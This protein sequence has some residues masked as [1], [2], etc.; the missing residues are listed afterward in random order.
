MT[1]MNLTACGRPATSYSRQSSLRPFPVMIMISA[2]WFTWSIFKQLFL[3]SISNQNQQ[4]PFYFIFA[5][6]DFSLSI[7]FLYF[8]LKVH[9]KTRNR[10]RRT[11]N[12]G[13]DNGD[14]C[15]GDCCCAYW[16]NACSIC[17]MARHTADYRNTH[18]ARCCTETGLDED[19]EPLYPF[20]AR[21]TAHVV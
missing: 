12:I 16:C 14:H 6:V 2:G 3:S 19:V 10:L 9:T 20:H 1:R 15:L 17:Q 11:Y 8:V 13:A 5:L 18:R 4:G 21:P 7:G